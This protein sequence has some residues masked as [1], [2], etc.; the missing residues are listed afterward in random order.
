[1]LPI[2]SEVLERSPEVN[3]TETAADIYTWYEFENY[4]F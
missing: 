4:I 3:F 1:M 2:I